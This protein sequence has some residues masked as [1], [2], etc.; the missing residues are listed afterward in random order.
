S[1]I[2]AFLITGFSVVLVVNIQTYGFKKGMQETFKDNSPPPKPKPQLDLDT[3]TD[4]QRTLVKRVKRMD[5]LLWTLVALIFSPALLKIFKID[6]FVSNL[7]S[8][9]YII[10]FLSGVIY[11][12]TWWLVNRKRIKALTKKVAEK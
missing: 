7:V 2:G 1:G 3:L 9:I 8:G 6:I 5:I 11:Y 12:Y 10:I 4:E